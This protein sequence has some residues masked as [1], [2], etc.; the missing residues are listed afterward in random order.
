MK[1][2]RLSNQDQEVDDLLGFLVD[3]AESVFKGRVSAIY[4]SG[5]LSYGDFIPGKSDING[6]CF[7]EKDLS[8]DG[9]AAYN[10]LVRG[11]GKAFPAYD[12]RILDGPV[13][14]SCLD[15]KEKLERDLGYINLTSLIQ[16]GKL[17]HGR[18]ILMS[19][20]APNRWELDT[21]VAQGVADILVNEPAVFP[22]STEEGGD[23][24]ARLSQDPQG[25]VDWLIYPARAFYTMKTG[26]I[27]SKRTAALHYCLSHNDRFKV[28]LEQA[29][30][31]RSQR[32]ET[33][34]ENQVK[35][36]VEVTVDFFWHLVNSV[37]AR[38][39]MVRKGEEEVCAP[40]EAV[41][42]FRRLLDVA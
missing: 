23:L 39:G 26:R 25:L 18:E 36:L 20:E 38:M 40:E 12:G 9:V 21:Q 1:F 30:D 10:E 37:Q 41:N 6:Y 32:V 42:R 33:I 8:S 15:D 35:V 29:I 22:C 27:A 2:D 5:S 19:V 28:W 17:I 4:I 7:F 16:S 11:V 34:P 31:Y 13:S 14:V 24:L 3:R